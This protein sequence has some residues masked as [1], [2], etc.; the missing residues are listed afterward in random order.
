[1]LGN[2]SQGVINCSCPEAG[3]LQV[4][5]TSAAGK[6]LVLS[7]AVEHLLSEANLTSWQPKFI[8]WGCLHFQNNKTEGVILEKL[9]CLAGDSQSSTY[10]RI[11]SVK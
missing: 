5:S 2:Q 9:K 7:C 10:T 1:M 3:P 8:K 11:S 6:R 4:A